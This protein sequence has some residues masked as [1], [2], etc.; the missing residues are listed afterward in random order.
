MTSYRG[1][2]TKLCQL[3]QVLLKSF[4]FLQLNITLS[5]FPC[6]ITR[7]MIMIEPSENKIL[8]RVSSFENEMRPGLT[9]TVV[10]VFYLQEVHP[11]FLDVRAKS[12]SRF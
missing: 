8:M 2:K 1:V 4:Y 11:S 3:Y 5:R 6:H 7:F 9:I 12:D 10:S